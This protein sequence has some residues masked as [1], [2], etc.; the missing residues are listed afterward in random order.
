MSLPSPLSDEAS[1]RTNQ[2]LLLEVVTRCRL[3]LDTEAIA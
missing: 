1:S 3:Q 2:Q